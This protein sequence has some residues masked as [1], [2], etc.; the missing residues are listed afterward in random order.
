VFYSLWGSIEKS[1]KLLLLLATCD[2]K[3]QKQLRCKKKFF[4]YIPKKKAKDTTNKTSTK[5]LFA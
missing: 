3:A 5:L 1:Q 4:F 2:F